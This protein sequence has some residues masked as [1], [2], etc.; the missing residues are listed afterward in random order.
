MVQFTLTVTVTAF[1]LNTP[2]KYR[3]GFSGG[4]S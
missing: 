3:P 4:L 2:M 1:G